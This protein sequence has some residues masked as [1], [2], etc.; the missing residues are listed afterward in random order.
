MVLRIFYSCGSVDR[1]AID[2]WV[3]REVPQTSA[4]LTTTMRQ[5][6]AGPSPDERDD[7]FSSA[8]SEATDGVISSVQ[9]SN[10][11]VIVEFGRLDALPAVSGS[12][13]RDFFLAALN[14]SLF[15]Y[16]RVI[17]VE[18]RI[19]GSCDDFWALLGAAECEIVTRAEWDAQ[20]A[21]YQAAG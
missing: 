21:D 9:L 20:A 6:V 17:S 16:D 14:A 2:T 19:Q 8:W 1:P 5:L 13:S 11:E 15:Q 18:Y 10:G 7:G 4:L 3:Y 12:P